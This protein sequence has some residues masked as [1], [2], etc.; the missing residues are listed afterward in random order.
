[1]HS[2]QVIFERNIQHLIGHVDY[3]HVARQAIYNGKR[4]LGQRC[5]ADL[6]FS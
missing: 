5:A 4:N 1:M 2:K 6:K 3:G